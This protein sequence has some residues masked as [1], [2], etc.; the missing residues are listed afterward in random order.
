MILSVYVIPFFI[1]FLLVFSVIKKK[2]AYEI[3]IKGSKQA[4]PLVESIFPYLIAIFL[5]NELFTRS[6]LLDV[7]IKITSPIF[8]LFGIPSEVI[9]LIVIKPLSGSGSFALLN[10]IYT[11]YGANSYVSFLASCLFG[12][13]ETIFYISSVYF[14]KCKNKKATKGIIISLIACFI[15]TCLC[16][17]ICKLTF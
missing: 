12:S 5:L 6:G 8:D 11:E 17:I 14:V 15:S 9:K 3:F 13:S 7:F 4:I 2:N 1:L 16:S 10:E